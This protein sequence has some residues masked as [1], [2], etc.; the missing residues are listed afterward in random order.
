MLDVC[1]LHGLHV[2]KAQ[3]FEDSVRGCLLIPLVLNGRAAATR[4][5]PQVVYD[6]PR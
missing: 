1:M 5:A 3:Q 6:P 4:K 2:A